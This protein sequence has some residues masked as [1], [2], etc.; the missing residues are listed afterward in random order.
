MC[1]GQ[2]FF[3]A[4]G[5]SIGTL[6][7][8]P[9]HIS[10]TC[11]APVVIAQEMQASPRTSPCFTQR[12]QKQSWRLGISPST[13]IG[14]LGTTIG[15][16]YH[17]ANEGMADRNK[18]IL[19][20]FT[21]VA[22]ASGKY[23]AV[24]GD[25]NRRIRQSCSEFHAS[26]RRTGGC[27]F[28][29][30]YDDGF[31]IYPRDA[32]DVG[33]LNIAMGRLEED[34]QRLPEIILWTSADLG[35]VAS[36]ESPT[37][38][39]E[40]AWRRRL[41]TRQTETEGSA[42][43]PTFGSPRTLRWKAGGQSWASTCDDSAPRRRAPSGRELNEDAAPRIT[44]KGAFEARGRFRA[45]AG[46]GG[47]TGARARGDAGSPRSSARGERVQ[48][49]GKWRAVAGSAGG[50]M[51]GPAE[52]L[53]AMRGEAERA[54]GHEYAAG[55][56]DLVKRLERVAR[57]AV[58]WGGRAARTW[59]RGIVA[60]SRCAPSCLEMAIAPALG[61]LEAPPSSATTSLQW[62]R[63]ASAI[64][65]G[66]PARCAARAFEA[67]LGAPVSRGAGGGAVALASAAA[68]GKNIA[69]TART[70]ARTAEWAAR[71]KL[72]RG[73]P[74]PRCCATTSPFM[75]RAI[76]WQEALADTPLAERLRGACRA[77]AMGAAKCKA[78]WLRARRPAAALIAA[79]KAMDWMTKAART[80]AVG[81]AAYDFPYTRS[82]TTPAKPSWG[83]GTE[84]RPIVDPISKSD[85]PGPDT[86][87]RGLTS[88]ASTGPSA[89]CTPRR[90]LRVHPLFKAPGVWS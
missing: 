54:D 81:D 75:A 39:A 22:T 77:R 47:P 16:A 89:S 20:S 84:R 86:Y 21:A 46:L 48:R 58:L 13:P 11:R 30:D 85:L 60:G 51:T 34:D 37:V 15:A 1:G 40:A 26:R 3:I 31:Y 9:Q 8:V 38:G 36:Q 25:F 72:R 42:S 64:L 74:A 17:W 56:S 66:S 83:F 53:Q 28:C 24:G 41:P 43:P 44:P 52:G 10:Y 7:R 50:L 33:E 23:W 45:A 32:G 57:R 19:G 78:P 76:A 71:E 5:N 49:R 27:E 82:A 88:R 2:E 65:R 35:L 90:P 67:H 68:P 6:E 62:P 73:R 80:V 29:D 63:A 12:M 55:H 70:A 87:C 69:A 18:A 61:E 79:A 4:N 14:K 59:Q